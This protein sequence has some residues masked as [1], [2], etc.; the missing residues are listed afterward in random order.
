M[1]K[2]LFYKNS[3]IL[4]LAAG[5]FVGGLVLTFALEAFA[6]VG[7]TQNP[8]TGYGAIGSDSSNNIAVGTSTTISGT[9]FLSLGATSDSSTYGGKFLENNTTPILLL[10]DDGAVSIATSTVTAGDTI[11]GDNLIVGGSLTTNSVAGSVVAGNVT[12][13]VF[14]SNIAPGSGIY[15]FPVSLGVNTSTASGLPQS[16]SVYGGGYFS[17]SVGI[18]TTTPSQKLDV[19]GNIQIENGAAL[20]LQ[21]GA[22]G[23][24]WAITAS[25]N[26]TNSDLLFMSGGA[27]RMRADTNGQF[28][29]GYNGAAGCTGA[30][31][32]LVN[33]YVGIGTTTP[34][35]PLS[36]SGQIN[37]TT[38]YCINGANCISAWPSGGGGTVTSIAAGSGLSGGTITSSGTISLN[39][40]AND[41]WTGTQ[42]FN[43]TTTVMGKLTVS[44]IDPVYAINGQNYATYN[45]AMTGEKE[46][47][48]GTFNL[49]CAGGTCSTI[50]DFNALAQGSD[51]WLFGKATNLP[52]NLNNLIVILTPS[53]DGNVWYTKN[54]AKG[55]LTVYGS[56]A[57]EVSYRLTAPRFDASQWP[58][59][60]PAGETPNFT[61]Y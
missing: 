36:V 10:R 41:T 43:G 2:N 38:G 57:G 52:S 33:G 18:G 28:C 1:K 5:A 11:I 47:S 59:T 30:S 49:L 54:V 56:Q 29:I 42:T 8:P 60:A 51:L 7:P 20:I 14:N 19:M 3:R 44:T 27:E 6:F 35:Y 13:G 45:A 24:N 4:A 50:V 58:N 46:E 21:P 25:Y 26:Y 55:T 16:L 17:G 53:F 40:A 37:A 23:N 12:P 15:T 32:L 34:A 48:A 61:I 9:K 31:G 39:L 22:A